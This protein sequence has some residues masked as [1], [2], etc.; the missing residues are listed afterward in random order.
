[1]F[2]IPS[3]LIATISDGEVNS[4]IL[5]RIILLVF[6]NSA[7]LV[8]QNGDRIESTTE[9]KRREAIVEEKAKSKMKTK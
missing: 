5:A 6:Q 8:K 4:A 9:H 1:V 2:K 7:A 3:L